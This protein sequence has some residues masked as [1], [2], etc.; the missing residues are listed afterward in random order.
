MR[1]ERIYDSGDVTFEQV[2]Y[3]WVK[4]SR[5]NCEERGIYVDR[6]IRKL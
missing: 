1:K 4:N 2:F 6:G 5:D 3:D